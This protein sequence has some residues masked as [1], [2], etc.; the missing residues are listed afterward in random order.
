MSRTIKIILVD[1]EELFRTGIAFML[2]REEKINIL[3]QS[4]NGKELLDYLEKA[5]ILPDIVLM[6]LKMPVLNGVETTK[7]MKEQYP[8]IDIIALSSYNSK[9]FILNMINEGASSYIIKNSSPTEMIKTINAVAEKGF[10]YDNSALNLIK[11]DKQLETRGNIKSV[12]DKNF[13]TSRENEV[14]ELICHQHSTKEIAE[15]LFISPRTVDEHRRSLLLK[16]KVKNLAGLVV[17]A[18]QN[19]LIALDEI[20]K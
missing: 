19:D 7:V 3:H 1:D 4:A 11:E 6:D 16:T 2:Q 8:E 12:L 9:A 10:Y 13:L 15:K 5:P 17:F 20:I 18:I 14:L